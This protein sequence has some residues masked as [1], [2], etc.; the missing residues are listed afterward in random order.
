MHNKQGVLVLCMA[1]SLAGSLRGQV[2]P[3][4]APLSTRPVYQS[5]LFWTAT[6]LIGTGVVGRLGG[7]LSFQQHV[8]GWVGARRSSADDYLQFAPLA[9]A[10]ALELGPWPSENALLQK[11]VMLVEAQGLNFVLTHAMKR[12]VNDTRP[13]GGPH[14]WPSGHTSQAFVAATFLH[15][16]YGRSLPWVSVLGFASAGAVAIFRISNDAHW[17]PDV[18]AGAGVGILS[19]HLVY[20]ANQRYPRLRL[21]TLHLPQHGYAGW[22]I[23]QVWE[24]P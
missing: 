3:Q 9:L 1:L 24:I 10:Y 4:P 23:T 21:A 14:A 19:T 13:D 8:R 16:E 18:L 6:G 11:T 22:A 17:Y 7:K 12:L 2:Q 5:P 20:W 15:L